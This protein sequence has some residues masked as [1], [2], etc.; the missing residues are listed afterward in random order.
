MMEVAGI[1]KRQMA[2][3][4]TDNSQTDRHHRIGQTSSPLF[5]LKLNTIHKCLNATLQCIAIS[6]GTEEHIKFTMQ[7]KRYIWIV[8]V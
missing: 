5:V 7:V 1:R 8:A 6:M 4:T 3:M 2:D